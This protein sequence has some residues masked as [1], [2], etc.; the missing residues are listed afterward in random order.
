VRVGDQLF[1]PTSVSPLLAASSLLPLLEA[2]EDA[3]LDVV[4]RLREADLPPVEGGVVMRLP[5]PIGDYVDFYS[6]RFHAANVGRI[7]RPD[8]EALPPNWLHLPIGYHG[9]SGTIVIDGTPVTR[10]VGQ[11]ARGEFGPTRRLDFELEL[12]FI[13]GAGPDRIPVDEAERYIFGLVL[14]NDWSARDIQVWEYQPLGPFQSKAFA[15]SISPWIVTAEALAPF[16]IAAPAPEKELLPYLRESGPGLYDIA[17][18]VALAPA[19]GSPTVI[20]RSS[21]RHMYWSAAQQLAHHAAGGCA[22]CVG[23]LLGSGTISGPTRDSCGSLLEITWNGRDPV[24]VDGGE[25]RFVEDG[26]TVTL[27]GWCEGPWRHIGFG[28]CETQVLPCAELP[29]AWRA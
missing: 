28:R 6:S 18:E 4:G 25:R 11:I 21:Y 7:F 16:R 23:D 22:M 9:R 3:W 24:A 8:A 19:G 29:Q 27:S 1:D 10:P 15:T 14:V 12:G 13:T 5:C 17:L 20:S 26:D 2:G